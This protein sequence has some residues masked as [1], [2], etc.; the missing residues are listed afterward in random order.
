MARI[1]IVTS[2]L[3]ESANSIA[4]RC[5]TGV[6]LTA[7][8]EISTDVAGVAALDA[9]AVGSGSG[10]GSGVGAGDGSALGVGS[11]DVAGSDDAVGAGASA[12]VTPMKVDI[13]YSRR[14]GTSSAG[15][16]SRFNGVAKRADGEPKSWR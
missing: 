7:S 15:G 16:R 8:S 5:L 2:A 11:G 13:R 14:P 10:V 1:V 3:A 9:E 4:A 6:G 12:A